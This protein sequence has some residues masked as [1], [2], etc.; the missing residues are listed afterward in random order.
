MDL[1]LGALLLAL[2]VL[3]LL[4]WMARTHGAAPAAGA[5]LG[6]LLLAGGCAVVFRPTGTPESEVE[7]RPI[8]VAER[9]DATSDACRACHPDQY[10][11]WHDSYHRTMTQLPS[12]QSIEA[13]WNQILTAT[14]THDDGRVEERRYELLR[15]GDE[16]WVRS[17]GPVFA[18]GHTLEAGARRIALVTGSHHEQFFWYATGDPDDRKLAKFPLGYSI[19]QRRWLPMQALLL[20]PP[21]PPSDLV[22][23]WNV[24]CF[25]CHSTHGRPGFETESTDL[26]A[27]HADTRFDT[28][29]TE[30]G[31][32]CEAC[33]G[34]A[35]EHVEA[36]QN[37]LRRY[38]SH[39]G[40]DTEG[41]VV[42]PAELDSRRS[43]DVC[44]SCHSIH[45]L[46]FGREEDIAA[47]NQTGFAY[48]PGDLLAEKRLIATWEHRDDPAFADVVAEDPRF[49]RNRFWPDGMPAVNGRE[50]N[51]LLN[52]PCY[53]RGELSCT[54]CHRM[55]Q[56]GDD[57]RGV[58]EWADDQLDAS[59]LGNEACTSCHAE[60]GEALEEHT[61]HDADSSGSLCYNC[62]MPNT[63]FGLLKQTR[64]HQVDVPD[65]ATA[66]QTGRPTACNL[67]HVD[68]TLA[69]TAGQLESGWGRGSPALDEEHRRTSQV[70]LEALRGDA[71]LRAMAAWHLGWEPAL[72]V[73]GD[74]WMVPLLAQLLEDP[75]AAVRYIAADSL[76]GRPGFEDFEYDYIAPRPR[77]EAARLE[78]L[79]R[80]RRSRPDEGRRRDEAVLMDDMSEPRWERIEALLSRRDDTPVFRQE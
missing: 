46:G 43:A 5:A 33:H 14:W 53:Q 77:L 56:A 59:K 27:S 7:G 22:G 37:P 62:H 55:H 72:E 29:V 58:K 40:L 60:L 31:I 74:D 12:E 54:S 57:P 61:R 25:R 23:G 69:W 44:G 6:A 20:S 67:C 28:Q 47:F 42:N 73:A 76:R 39:L 34:G 36:Y 51:G 8:E 50:Y 11:S 13:R 35:R 52:T 79:E 45:H 41:K 78:A 38:A 68:A 17:S 15:S 3:P 75:Y 19:H 21:T 10:A 71:G 65:V 2:G 16:F 48:R 32:A 49:F 80:W 63:T 4:L 66:L 70:A 24:I 18:S 9:A 30:F 1:A 26:V 64:S